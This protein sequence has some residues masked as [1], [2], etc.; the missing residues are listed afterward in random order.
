MNILE[1][2][3][4]Y[5]EKFAEQMKHTEQS[6]KYHGEGNV[7]THTQMVC[8]A[9]ISLDEYKELDETKQNILYAAALLHDIGKI[10]TTVF[11][12]GDWHSPHHA[13]T[14][15]RMARELLFKEFNMGGTKELMQMRE[16]ICTLIR[17]H[18][19]PP[20]AIE[21]DDGF[22]GT[23][24]MHRIAANSLLMPDFSIKMLC[25]LAKADTL[26]RVCDDQDEVIEKIEF[27]K[28][29]AIEE[30]CYEGCYNFPSEYTRRLFLSGKPV[31]KD[32]DQYD[33]TWGTVYMM[34]GLPGVGKDYT[35]KKMLGGIPMV[36]LDEIRKKNKV[37]ATDNQGAVANAAKEFAKDHLRKHEP[38]VWNATNLTPQMREQLI[39]MFESYGANV[40]IIYVESSYD[41][42]SKQNK[43]RAAIVPQDV[44]DNMLKK[45]VPPLMTEAREIEWVC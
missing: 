42:L 4:I 7:H 16:T 14:G 5:N 19:F 38:F 6:P 26:G 2:K 30:G 29:L 20:H 35:I 15:S 23:I 34:S 3:R 1:L 37:K 21:Y 13:S 45:L 22:F 25:I 44:I 9:L 36:S 17:F 31:W 12:D 11:Q 43:N 24:K 40:K 10:K 28:E 32:S 39:E 41:T 8:K 27:C 18:S 33:S